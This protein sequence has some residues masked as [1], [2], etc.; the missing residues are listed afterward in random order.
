MG[1]AVAHPLKRPGPRALYAFVN[2]SSAAWRSPPVPPRTPLRTLR[3]PLRRRIYSL[4]PFPNNNP[5]IINH[6]SPKNRVLTYPRR[7]IIYV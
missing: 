1:A 2:T 4:K 3:A 5:I 6:N 7:H